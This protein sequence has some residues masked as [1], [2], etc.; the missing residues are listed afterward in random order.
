[1]TFEEFCK[2]KL[3]EEYYMK[4]S[5]EEHPEWLKY[6]YQSYLLKQKYPILDKITANRVFRIDIGKNCETNK[7]SVFIQELCDDCFG[8]D[9]DSEE[10]KQLGNAFLELSKII[11]N[12]NR[13]GE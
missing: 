6:D 2:Q 10:L 9:L 12:Y 5:Y 3:E 13:G 4:D 11:D 8:V 1:M 7:V